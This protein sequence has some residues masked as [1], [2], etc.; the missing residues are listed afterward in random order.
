VI[1]E[2]VARHLEQ[3][4]AGLLHLRPF[5][6]TQPLGEHILGHVRGIAGIVHALAQ[7]VQDPA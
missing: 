7:E 3:E 4:G 5:T 1:T 6:V 2:Q